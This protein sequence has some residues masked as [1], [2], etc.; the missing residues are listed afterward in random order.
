M[1]ERDLVKIEA[2]ERKKLARKDKIIK[3]REEKKRLAELK[4]FEGKTEDEIKLIK[5]KDVVFKQ[6]KSEQVKSLLNLGL[7]KKEIKSLK[8]E[9]DRV[10]KIIN[11]QNKK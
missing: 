7:T 10:N 9:D 8:Y 5:R 3:D 1:E 6:T 2:K 4:R 11:L